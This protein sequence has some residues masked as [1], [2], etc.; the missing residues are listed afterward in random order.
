MARKINNS[1]NILT[2]TRINNKDIKRDVEIL[3]CSLWLKQILKLKN[4]IFEILIEIEIVWKFKSFVFSV[5]KK[6]IKL[7]NLDVR[8]CLI[9]DHLSIIKFKT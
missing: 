2:K 5:K 8:K 7:F 3:L 4:D 6:N 1:E 9:L